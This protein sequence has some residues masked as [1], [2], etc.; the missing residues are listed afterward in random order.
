MG[1]LTMEENN[2]RD[3][4]M[5]RWLAVSL[6]APRE[7]EE[8]ISNFL[9]EQGARGVEE[10]EE[11][12]KG[13][14]L[15]AYIPQDGKEKRVLRALHRYLKS[16]RSLNPEISDTQIE[17]TT[18]F[19][20]DWGENWKRFFK[21]LRVTSRFVVKPPWSR[22]RL[23]KGQ[24]V[25]HITPGM[26]FGTGTHGTTK[27]SIRALERSLK[28]K[29]LSVLDVG[30]GSGILSIAAAKLGAG[31]VLGLDI[32]GA[33][34]E[35]A[36]ENV[37][38]NNVGN[39]VKIRKGR[40]GDVRKTFDVVVANIDLRSLKRMRSPLLRHLKSQGIL[41]LSGILEGER[42]RLRQHYLET[43]D[44]QSAKKTQ[45]EG[46]ACLILKKK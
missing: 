43:G 5:R 45:E 13:K 19:E 4:P 36:R 29:G 31:E 30:T 39:I 40:I 24:M 38:Q 42:E 2:G 6:L 37:E 28:R 9:M 25:I 26:A 21:P 23:Q 15:K 16:L 22:T 17:T 32:D 1:E 27:L 10:L 20:Q 18:I 3:R 46:W 11:D 44:F 33:A 14:R 35:N 34:V 7:F 12:S 41:I 8:G